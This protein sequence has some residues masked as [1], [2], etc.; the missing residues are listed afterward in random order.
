MP[1]RI[2]SLETYFHKYLMPILFIPWGGVRSIRLSFP[3]I[4]LVPMLLLITLWAFFASI[5]WWHA[6][7]LKT[8]ILDDEVLRVKGYVK[9]LAIPFSNILSIEYCFFMLPHLTRLRLRTTTAFGDRI[10][11]YSKSRITTPVGLRSTFEELQARIKT[12]QARR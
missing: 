2:H 8:V 3:S 10:I 5:V 7:R 4:T 12:A 1:I 9:E 6:F 11:Y